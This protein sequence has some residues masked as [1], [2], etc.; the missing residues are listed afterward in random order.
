VATDPV[1][2]MRIDEDEAYAMDLTSDFGDR[3]YFFCSDVCKE[4]FD[5]KPQNY[6]ERRTGRSGSRGRA[7]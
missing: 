4:E 1:C 5:R 3:T 7:A 2:G 6:V